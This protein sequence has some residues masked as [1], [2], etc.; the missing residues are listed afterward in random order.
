MVL[1]RNKD[2][3][4]V[5]SAKLKGKGTFMRQM[6]KQTDIKLGSLQYGIENF[7]YK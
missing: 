5:M 1:M 4:V 2:F 6:R 7:P 3:Q